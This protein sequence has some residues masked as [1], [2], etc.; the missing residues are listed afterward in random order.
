M[1]SS[2]RSQAASAIRIRAAHGHAC[3]LLRD[4]SSMP[5]RKRSRCVSGET[6]SASGLLRRLLLLDLFVVFRGRAVADCDLSRLHR[7]GDLA[8]Q[9]D[10]QQAVVEAC[11]L[12]LHVIS[13]AEGAAELPR[14][15]ALI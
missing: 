8:H 14:R 1:R 4:R 3:A 6:S 5:P 10:L 13:K 7:L 15:N 11:A 2:A 9:L 12:H